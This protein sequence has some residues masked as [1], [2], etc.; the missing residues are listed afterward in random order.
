MQEHDERTTAEPL[1]S[2][3]VMAS[4]PLMPKAAVSSHTPDSMYE[5]AWLLQMVKTELILE[6]AGN[7]NLSWTAPSGTLTR[8]SRT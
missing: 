1:A 6:P 3:R 2:T 4:L 8:S 5:L 7:V